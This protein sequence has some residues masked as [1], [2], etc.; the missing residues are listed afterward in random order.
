M[1]LANPQRRLEIEQARAVEKTGI[2][3]SLLLALPPEAD[4]EVEILVRDPQLAQRVSEKSSP[5][6]LA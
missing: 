5:P 4:C 1:A 3:R 2:A 6:A